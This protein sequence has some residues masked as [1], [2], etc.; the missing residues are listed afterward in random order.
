MAINI[1]N[2]NPE[3]SLL[4]DNESYL[5]EVSDCELHNT[6]GGATPATWGAYLLTTLVIAGSGASIGGVIG[7]ITRRRRP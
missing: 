4:F 7:F 2:L 1:N 6:V 5:D 3:Y